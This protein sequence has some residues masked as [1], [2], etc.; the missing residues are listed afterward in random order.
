MQNDKRRAEKVLLNSD[1]DA[2]NSAASSIRAESFKRPSNNL[3]FTLFPCL[4]FP[5]RFM[6]MHIVF[7][8]LRHV[9]SLWEPRQLGAAQ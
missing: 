8:G 7:A 1:A 6:I 3:L 5:L 9:G 2:V 4:L